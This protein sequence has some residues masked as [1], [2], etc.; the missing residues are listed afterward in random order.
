VLT[1]ISRAVLEET[2][3]KGDLVPL[4]KGP[5]GEYSDVGQAGIGVRKRGKHADEAK[6]F[7][8]YFTNQERLSKGG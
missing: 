1:Q 5:A 8:A 4:P 6:K 7:L 2:R 3:F